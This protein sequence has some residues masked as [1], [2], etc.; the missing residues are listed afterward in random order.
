MLPLS[1]V[2]ITD[3]HCLGLGSL[4]SD[5]AAEQ[6]LNDSTVIERQCMP[7]GNRIIHDIKNDSSVP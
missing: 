2:C 7:S 6:Q 3:C 5:K 4:A 1:G